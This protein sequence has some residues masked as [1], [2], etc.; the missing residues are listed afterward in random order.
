MQ[1]Y[2]GFR[3]FFIRT[4][5]WFMQKWVRVTG[6]L[7]SITISD[8]TAIMGDT[9]QTKQMTL[10]NYM[11]PTRSTQASC[12]IL[13]ALTTNFEIKFGMIHMLSVFRGLANENP[14]QHICGIMKYN[15]MTE[16]SLKLKL[17]PFSLKEK[18]Q[19]LASFSPTGLNF[20][21]GR[22]A[23]AF[24]RKLYLKQKTATTRQTLNNFLQSQGETFFTY[25]ERFKDHLLE[26]SHHKFEKNLFNPNSL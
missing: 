8:P 13:L 9:N 21:M 22:L 16:E 7:E 6:R 14:Y 18:N 23:K 20:H 5:P 11:Y 19:S 24:Y 17:F 25:F 1:S 10:K 15:Q 3:K 2:L 12:I 26:C 4:V